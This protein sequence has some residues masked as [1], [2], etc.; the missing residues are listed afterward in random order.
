MGKY[1]KGILG[2]I[3]GIVGTVVGSSWRDIYYF[4]SKPKKSTKAPSLGQLEHRGGFTLMTDFMNGDI[5][6]IFNI[7]FQSQ[8]N[9]MTAFNAAFSQNLKHAVTGVYP[10]LTIDYPN[11]VIAKGTLLDAPFIAMATTEDAQMDLSWVNNAMPGST[12]GTDLATIAVYNPTK[13][14]WAIK[15]DAAARSVGL[16]D[17]AVPAMWSGD[18]VYVWLYFVRADKKKVSDSFYVGSAVVQ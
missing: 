7:G 13:K 6:S 16:Y 4:R 14:Q 8:A 18:S 17:F 10:A 5:A 3:S 2:T 9:N 1:E 15:Q 12:N 11:F